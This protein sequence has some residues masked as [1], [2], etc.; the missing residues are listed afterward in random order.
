[1]RISLSLIFLLLFTTI[2]VPANTEGRTNKP[3][4]TSITLSAYWP[5]DSVVKVYFVRD[6][7]LPEEQQI[8]R[9]TIERWHPDSR[10]KVVD[11]PFVFEGES[12]GL[13]DCLACLTITRQEVY[14]S[15]SQYR[16]SFNRLRYDERGHLFSAWIGIDRA[17]NRSQLLKDLILKALDR[18][19][20][21]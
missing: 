18:G 7:F 8:I 19:L 12:S 17:V 20:G 1:M 11:V 13:I 2:S 15:N 4:S 5:A 10:S 6:Q 16:A 14:T 21:I 9:E 3:R